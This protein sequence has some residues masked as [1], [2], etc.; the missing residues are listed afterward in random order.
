MILNVCVS[1]VAMKDREGEEQRQGQGDV[2]VRIERFTM[3]WAMEL[4][5]GHAP[6]LRVPR[7]TEAFEDSHDHDALPSE[8]DTINRPLVY[9]CIYAWRSSPH[10]TSW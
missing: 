8:A 2:I 9:E 10:S 4:R 7:A 5:D 6:G 3:L 1:S